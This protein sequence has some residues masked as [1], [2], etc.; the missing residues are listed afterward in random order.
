MHSLTV[1]PPLASSLCGVAIG[2]DQTQSAGKRTGLWLLVLTLHRSGHVTLNTALP[3][4]FVK[5]WR[6]LGC[7]LRFLQLKVSARLCISRDE[8]E[9]AEVK[10]RWLSRK[11][12]STCTCA[13]VSAGR[14]AGEPRKGSISKCRQVCHLSKG[15]INLQRP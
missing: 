5:G 3:S 11:S 10:N 7:F 8:K 6:R 13:V 1:C 14:G 4:S 12:V 15:S 2:K 9:P